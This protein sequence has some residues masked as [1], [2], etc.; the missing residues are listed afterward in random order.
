MK[1]SLEQQYMLS[2]L[3]NQYH[4][5]WCHGPQFNI[6]MISYQY[7]KSHCADKTILRPA[8]LHSGISY[9][10]KMLSLYWIEALVILGARASAG[11]GYYPP[12]LDYSISSIRR[13]NI[14]KLR[15]KGCHFADIFIFSNKKCCIFIQILVRFVPKYPINNKPSLV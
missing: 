2:V 4:A 9:T 8:Y 13:V 7:R 3:H 12:K 10:G 11:M 1:L 5:F 15:K 6:K 14:L